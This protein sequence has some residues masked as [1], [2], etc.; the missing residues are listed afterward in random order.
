MQND[1]N[2]CELTPYAGLIRCSQIGVAY[3]PTYLSKKTT[4]HIHLFSPHFRIPTRA[5]HSRPNLSI[6]I[7][8]VATFRKA[9]WN[10]SP[11]FK[12]MEGKCGSPRVEKATS[13]NSGSRRATRTRSSR[14]GVA[15]WR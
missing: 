12:T 11:I 13:E 10:V 9:E 3:L 1:V 8:M 2:F 5:C 6:F 7:W 14:G 15:S 4:I